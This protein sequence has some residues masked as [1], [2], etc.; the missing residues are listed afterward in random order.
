MNL[1]IKHEM[2]GNLDNIQMELG[3]IEINQNYELGNC[4]EIVD[5][6]KKGCLFHAKEIN[7]GVIYKGHCKLDKNWN[8]CSPTKVMEQFDKM[9]GNDRSNEDDNGTASADKDNDA[10]EKTKM[11]ATARAEKDNLP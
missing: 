3:A 6:D 1:Q 4:K 8:R 7:I 2:V 9:C 10:T 5:G 11:A